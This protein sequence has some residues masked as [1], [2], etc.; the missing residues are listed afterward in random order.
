M[1][2]LVVLDGH[3]YPEGAYAEVDALCK[4]KGIAFAV[5]DCKNPE[6]VVQKA[7]DADACLCI[8]VKLDHS[9]LSRLPR[10]RMVVRCGIG[11][12]N[13]VLPDHTALGIYACNVP[14]YG[15]EEVA[16]HALGQILTLERKIVFYNSRVH[17]GVWNEDEG[18]TMRR[19]SHRTLGFLGFGRIARKLAEYATV[20]GYTLI[21]Y[22]PFLPAEFFEKT[23]ARRVELDTLFR[24]SDVISVHAP[25]TPETIHVI[26]DAN[27]AKARDGLFIVNTARGTLVD[28][29]A[30]IRA[31]ESGKLGGI[32]LDVLEEEPPR[33]L[34]SQLFGRDNVILSPHIAYR[35]LESFAALKRMAGETAVH[36]LSGGEPYNVVNREVIGHAKP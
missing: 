12:D 3:H 19:V 22:D 20:L 10:M 24:E 34:C 25:A 11:V 30:V 29:A 7:Q 16:I 8:Y 13:L 23:G 15:I 32:A 28:T 35:S 36:F 14:D 27:L 9:V 17:A 31:L 33:E 26:N 21:A 6:E 5:L 4:A 1:K 18:Y 2:K